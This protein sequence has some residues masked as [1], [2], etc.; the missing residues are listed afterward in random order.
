MSNIER[1]QNKIKS[2]TIYTVHKIK[3]TNVLMLKL[4]FTQNPSEIR[5]V[6]I[7]PDNLQ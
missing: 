6:S 2:I 7:H 3:Q 1:I 5:H 4:Y